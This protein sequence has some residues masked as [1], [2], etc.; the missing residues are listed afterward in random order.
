MYSSY[1]S[2]LDWGRHEGGEEEPDGS[3]RDQPGT[4]GGTGCRGSVCYLQGPNHTPEEA[5]EP[6][7]QDLLSSVLQAAPEEPEE[8]G[9]EE[10]AGREEGQ[11]AGSRGWCL[12]GEDREGI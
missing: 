3:S 12:T 4:R 11:E 2:V 9:Y 1:L 5:D 8:Q 7:H 6:P 10:V